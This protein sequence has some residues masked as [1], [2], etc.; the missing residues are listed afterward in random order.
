M[1]FHSPILYIDPATWWQGKGDR[2][3]FLLIDL[4]A[5]GS[6]YPLFALLFGFSFVLLT[7]KISRKQIS[8]T[9]TVVR[10]L[11][12]LLFIGILHAF[13]IWHGDILIS[14]AFLGFILLFFQKLSGRSLL[15][16]GISLYGIA[17][18]LLCVFLFYISVRE[19]MSEVILSNQAAIQQSLQTYQQGTFLE[20][21]KQRIIDWS[22][23]NR[24]ANI[25][26]LLVSIFPLFLMGAG[27]AKLK[28]LEKPQQYQN[29]L[30]QVIVFSL[31]IGILLKSLPYIFG[32]NLLTMYIQDGIGGLCL[33]IFYGSTVIR[34]SANSFIQKWLTPFAIIGRMSIS[35]YLF[36]SFVSTMIFYHYGLG[37]Y[38]ELS[39]PQGTMLVLIIYIFQIILSQLWLKLFRF[40]PIEAIWRSITY[41]KEIKAKSS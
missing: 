24:L 38:G 15:F 17:V 22:S 8:L 28:W 20:I 19:P 13:F 23:T 2:L 18:L 36:Q 9:I 31:F 12:F 3:T 26:L 29:R 11:L 30:L 6:F 27:L 16:G 37:L 25:P 34:L 33:A 39:L 4:F 1:S 10:R 5:Q 14:Y 32:K 40:G 21:T 35:N 41:G 7:N